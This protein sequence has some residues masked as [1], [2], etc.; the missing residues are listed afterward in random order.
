MSHL[1]YCNLIS[2]YLLAYLIASLRNQTLSSRVWIRSAQHNQSLVIFY[3][4]TSAWSHP[5]ISTSTH[6]CAQLTAKKACLGRQLCDNG[7]IRNRQAPLRTTH[8]RI[9]I[10]Y[11]HNTCCA[12]WYHKNC[13]TTT[14][15]LT[16]CIR[17]YLAFSYIFFKH[18]LVL[19][20][21][22]VV[23]RLKH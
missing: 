19:I 13:S 15:L 3:V 10:F 20:N 14:H 6:T 16:C 22:P 11:F 9:K 7:T 4:V 23:W 8:D 5:R 21:T 12:E 2:T 18:K 1:N 17:K